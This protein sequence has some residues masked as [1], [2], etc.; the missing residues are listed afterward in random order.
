[1]LPVAVA[2]IGADGRGVGF[3]RSRGRVW[4]VPP[5]WR[6]W[7]SARRR[8]WRPSRQRRASVARWCRCPWSVVACDSARRLLA[9]GPAQRS[10]RRAGVGRGRVGID[11]AC[12][13]RHGR[14]AVTAEAA[15]MAA[16]AIASGAVAPAGWQA[17]AAGALAAAAATAA[18][19]TGGD[20]VRRVARR[21][22]LRCAGRRGRLRKRFGRSLVGRLIVGRFRRLVRCESADFALARGARVSVRQPASARCPARGVAIVRSV[23]PRGRRP[24]V[25][26]SPVVRRVRRERRRNGAARRLLLGARSLLLSAGLPCCRPAPRNCRFRAMG[27]ICR[28][29]AAA[30]PGKTRWVLDLSSRWTRAAF[31]E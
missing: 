24:R 22:V 30:R 12:V 27:R 18:T 25:A 26:R 7:L 1:M 19:A 16:A 28:T 29:S 11:P 14:E 5:P 15:A 2:S 13:W 4:A 6:A 23:A 10:W 21:C 20:R 17:V 31:R 3:A 8:Q 9:G